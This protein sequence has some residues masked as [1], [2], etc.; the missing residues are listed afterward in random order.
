MLTVYLVPLNLANTGSTSAAACRS[1]TNVP[2]HAVY[3]SGGGTSSSCPWAC[4]TG[5]IAASNMGSCIACPSLPANSHWAVAA[6]PD[7]EAGSAATAPCAWVCNSGYDSDGVRCLPCSVEVQ[8]G[9]NA[10]WVK[11]LLDYR[12][13]MPH[14]AS[15]LHKSSILHS[16][17]V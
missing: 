5:Y 7:P 14:K 4:N 16:Q 1:C 9:A 2:S 3:L 15:Y 6:A 12:L 8:L 10:S 11:V 17:I 13:K